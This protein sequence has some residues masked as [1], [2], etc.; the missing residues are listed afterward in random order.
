ML[1]VIPERA[2]RREPGIQTRAQ[3]MHLDSGSGAARRPGM[4]VVMFL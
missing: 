1:S 4:T 3:W 2:D